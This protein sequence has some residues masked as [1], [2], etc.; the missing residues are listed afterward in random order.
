MSVLTIHSPAPFLS[1]DTRDEIKSHGI[2]L[3]DFVSNIESKLRARGE[4]DLVERM[5]D[6]L[7]E[8][9]HD[10]RAAKERCQ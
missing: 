5:L 8:A 6:E 3:A 1:I 10:E 4:H 7:R 9:A 2:S